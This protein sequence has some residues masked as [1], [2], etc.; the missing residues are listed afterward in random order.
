MIKKL[1]KELEDDTEIR[2]SKM[3][4]R[5]FIDITK[6]VKDTPYR[7]KRMIREEDFDYVDIILEHLKEEMKIYIKRR[8]KMNSRKLGLNTDFYDDL[9]S[10]VCE[11][12]EEYY[13]RKYGTMSDFKEA[14]E[15]YRQHIK[16]SSM[17]DMKMPGYIFN[18][19]IAKWN[20]IL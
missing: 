11:Q 13:V 15:E 16:S 2:F 4:G 12:L 3:C 1:L 14:W 17:D 7:I 6:Y 18:K 9:P 19:Y 20:E 5:Y 8:E 10:I